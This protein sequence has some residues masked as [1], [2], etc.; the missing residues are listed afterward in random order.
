MQYIAIAH[1]LTCRDLLCLNRSNR[2]RLLLTCRRAPKS[3]H[4]DMGVWPCARLNY[5]DWQSQRKTL[6]YISNSSNALARDSAAGRC[7]LVRHA[8]GY[9]LTEFQIKS[10]ILTWP[11]FAASS[12]KWGHNSEGRLPSFHSTASRLNTSASVSTRC[13]SASQ[14][15][16]PSG[17]SCAGSI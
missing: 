17:E 7:Y 13:N 4:G 11:S 8:A 2:A 14:P 3:R 10:C 16:D 6:T 12:A 1:R 9:C 15:A 5:L